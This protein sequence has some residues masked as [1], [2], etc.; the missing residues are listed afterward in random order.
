MAR[1]HNRKRKPKHFT[2]GRYRFTKHSN[3]FTLRT[4]TAKRLE[5]LF[6]RNELGD[7]LYSLKYRKFRK[8][9]ILNF[10]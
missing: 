4:R 3:R 7:M 2:K 1:R 6:A 9:I 10:K 8:K 5:L